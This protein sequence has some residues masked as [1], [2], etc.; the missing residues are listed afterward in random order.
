MRERPVTGEVEAS[1]SK[2]AGCP[3][4]VGGQSSRSLPRDRHSCRARPRVPADHT[5]ERAL[6]RRSPV[7]IG[8]GPVGVRSDVLF[9]DIADVV[10]AW[11]TLAI[12][13]R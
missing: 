13:S 9:S 1:R 3:A 7:I 8:S 10:V 11:V 2:V 6:L 4:N 12:C 5:H